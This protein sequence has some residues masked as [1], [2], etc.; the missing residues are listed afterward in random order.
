MSHFENLRPMDRLLQYSQPLRQDIVLRLILRKKIEAHFFNYQTLNI[1]LFSILNKISIF[2]TNTQ[3]FYF[4]MY[5]KKQSAEPFFLQI[6]YTV[7]LSEP[8]VIL[9]QE[10]NLNWKY[11]CIFNVKFL[12]YYPHIILLVSYNCNDLIFHIKKCEDFKKY[13]M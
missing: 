2:S 4:H 3:R 13:T 9:F 11:Y 1:F 7:L 5:I 10:W 6:F 12:C 8:L